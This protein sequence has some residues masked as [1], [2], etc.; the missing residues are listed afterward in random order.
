MLAPAPHSLHVLLIQLRW[1]MLVP[2]HT[3]HFLL[4]RLC[5]HCSGLPPRA[6]FSPLLLPPSSP[7]GA[8]RLLL[9]SPLCFSAAL[10]LR[11][12]PLPPRP[13]VQAQHSTQLRRPQLP[14]RPLPLAQAPCPC[15]RCS[16]WEQRPRNV[17]GSG[18]ALPCSLLRLHC[19]V[20]DPRV[21]SSARKLLTPHGS[22]RTRCDCVSDPGVLA[23]ACW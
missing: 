8:A 9:P 5:S 17:S 2:P 14:A 11:P 22:T 6:R 21:R 13:T 23:A 10:L 4:C 20:S 3:L 15:R 18:L 16:H 1:Q 7:S 12:L 19:L